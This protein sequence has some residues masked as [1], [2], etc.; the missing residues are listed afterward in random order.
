MEAERTWATRNARGHGAAIAEIPAHD[1]ARKKFLRVAT[2]GPPPQAN[3]LVDEE[4]A[5]DFSKLFQLCNSACISLGK[6]FACKSPCSIGVKPL[7]GPRSYLRPP[8]SRKNAL[9]Q[10]ISFREW[11]ATTGGMTFSAQE[12][13]DECFPL[14]SKYSRVFFRATLPLPQCYFSDGLPR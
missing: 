11:D 5:A 3:G 13:S 1:S 6:N 8:Q 2:E 9:A 4:A 7:F 12:K 14:R 10:P